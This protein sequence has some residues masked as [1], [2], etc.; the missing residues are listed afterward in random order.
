MS[1]LPTY[2]PVLPQVA[3]PEQ[4]RQM[5]TDS[6]TVL[7][8][9]KNNESFMSGLKTMNNSV[10]ASYLTGL[11]NLQSIDQCV[12]EKMKSVQNGFVSQ[13]SQDSIYLNNK[14]VVDS[15]DCATY[16]ANKSV[17]SL[18]C[19]T[20]RHPDYSPLSDAEL[21]SNLKYPGF[22]CRTLDVTVDDKGQ[23]STYQSV[24]KQCELSNPKTAFLCQ[25]SLFF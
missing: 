19:A 9:Q 11:N 7:Y 8:N 12:E 6:C 17:A 5:M 22:S 20:V 24:M 13:L 14:S 16:N 18:M 3:N 23:P 25:T 15:Q 1:Q 10:A 4:F 21:S 2:K